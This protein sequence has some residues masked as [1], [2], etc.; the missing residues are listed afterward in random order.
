[1]FDLSGKTALI[2]GGNSGIGLGMAKGLARCG[3]E[4]SIWGRN[5]EKTEQAYEALKSY[6]PKITKQICDVSNA[7]SVAECFHQTLKDHGRVDGCFA[8]A[9]MGDNRGPFDEIEDEA[10]T[11]VMNTNL[12]G[13]FYVFRLAARHM[14]ERAE[15]GDAFGRLVGTSSLSAL[16]GMPG[17]QHYVS[18]KGGLISM[19]RSLAVEYAR[20]GVTANSIIPGFVETAMTDD[21][22]AHPAFTKKV[23][24]RIPMRRVGIGDDFAALAAYI[25][26]DGSSWHTGQDFIVDGGYWI[27]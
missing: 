7:S 21:L 9:G 12:G 3:C 20:F 10:W 2:T 5:K 23:L 24:P 16:S 27:F 15:A 1:M 26:S 25:M 8:N 17:G 14:R 4:V 22:I 13:A 11:K 18:S 19:M 6:G